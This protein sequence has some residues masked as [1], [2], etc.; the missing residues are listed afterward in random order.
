MT[1]VKK[2]PEQKGIRPLA[3]PFSL[4][5][6]KKCVKYRIDAAL[7]KH[8]HLFDLQCL[9]MQFETQDIL[10]YLRQKDKEKMRSRGIKEVKDISGADAVKFLG[11]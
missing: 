9:I 7:I 8:L 2:L 1:L 3:V 5:I 11:R 6:L 10:D 4:T